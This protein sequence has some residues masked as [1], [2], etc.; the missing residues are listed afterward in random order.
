[1]SMTAVVNVPFVGSREEKLHPLDRKLAA[2]WIAPVASNERVRAYQRRVVEEWRARWSPFWARHTILAWC[3]RVGLP[4]TTISL[5]LTV[6]YLC[7]AYSVLVGT[8]SLISG[9]GFLCLLVKTDLVFDAVAVSTTKWLSSPLDEWLSRFCLPQEI[10][11]KSFL[12]EDNLWVR[13]EHFRNDP[14]LVVYRWPFKLGAKR[15]IAYW[16]APGFEP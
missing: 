14:F 13:V 2:A 6:L 10:R 8:L 11:S 7:A 9:I 12:V 1:M 3:V 4:T 16:D 15:Y 5:C